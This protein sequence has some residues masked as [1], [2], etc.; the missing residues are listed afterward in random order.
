MYLIL[1]VF[2]CVTYY[3]DLAGLIVEHDDSCLDGEVR[4]QDGL[5]YNNNGTK[6]GR[7]EICF[8]R[9]WGTVCSNSFGIPDARV[10]CGQITGFER[11]GLK[12]A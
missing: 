3:F 6:D 7:L 10:A 12:W 5:V 11:E 2:M 4:L 8:N 1:V 9:V